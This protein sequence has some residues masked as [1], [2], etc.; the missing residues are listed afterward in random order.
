MRAFEVHLNG[1]RLCLA[2]V[3]EDGVLTAI[4]DHVTGPK[5]SSLHLRVGG[6]VSPIGKH[7]IWRDRRLQVGD[8]VLVKIAETVSVDKPRKKIYL[9]NPEAD[10]KRQKAYVRA[11]AKK[12][13]WRIDTRSAP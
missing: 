12:F 9:Q 2:G 13:G 8:E 7:F 4:I 1:K 11:M 3:G 10:E 5:G 6:L